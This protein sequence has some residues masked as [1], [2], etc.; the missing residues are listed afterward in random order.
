M[1]LKDELMPRYAGLIYNGFW[2]SPERE[3]LQVAI[4]HSQTRVEGTVRMKLYKGG[5]HVTGR[6]SPNSLYSEKVVTFEDDAGAYDQ[7][8][9]EGFIKLNALRLRL[10]GRRDRV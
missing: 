1:H 9:A 2:F 6:K 4:D 8:D 7:R 10:L 5:I 3:M